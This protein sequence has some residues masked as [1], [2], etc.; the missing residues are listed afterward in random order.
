MFWGREGD[1]GKERG[2][3]GERVYFTWALG[4]IG[5]PSYEVPFVFGACGLQGRERGPLWAAGNAPHM[6]QAGARAQLEEKETERIRSTI[7]SLSGQGAGRC[8]TVF[9]KST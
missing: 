5:R 8:C 6:V 9:S 4:S 7:L 1:W 2:V 3:K